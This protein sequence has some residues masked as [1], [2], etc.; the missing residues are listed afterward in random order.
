MD[1]Q[2]IP[3]LVPLVDMNHTTVSTPFWSE[4]PNILCNKTCI[5]EFFPT[6]NMTYNEKLNAISRSVILLTVVGLFLTTNRIRLFLIGLATLGIIFFLHQ[7]HTNQESKQNV[8][9]GLEI[10]RPSPALDYLQKNN[11]NTESTVFQQPTV[12]NPFGNVM[13]SDYDYNP[14]KLPAPPASN[15]MI[16]DMI[17]QN[18][19]KLIQ[20]ANPGQPD[21]DK[22]LFHDLTE[23]LGFE[24]SMRQ[25]NTNPSTTIP[26][27]QGAFAEF[28]YGS[29]VSCKEGNLFACARNTSHY[30][31]Y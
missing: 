28:C 7:H 20:E 21:I 24:Q 31:N 25:F 8:K 26:N 16:N 6:E 3:P 27:D 15:P 19:K 23:Q 4:N 22:K 11:L 30:T 9:E 14:N 2:I 5:M 12:E 17:T 18:A 13:M 10:L 29:M 1:S